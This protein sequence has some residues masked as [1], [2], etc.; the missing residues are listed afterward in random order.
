MLMQLCA[1]GLP[2]T[3]FKM[4]WVF[5]HEIFLTHFLHKI[6]CKKCV[7]K[8]LVKKFLVKKFLVKKF[9]VKKFLVKKFIVKKYRVKNFVLKNVVL[10]LSTYNVVLITFNEN[11]WFFENQNLKSIT[12]LGF[13]SDLEINWN[14]FHCSLIGGN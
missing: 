4:F 11:C 2:F 6:F 9:L 8:F 13:G 7:K 12:F 10:K 14:T 1:I 5:W 3:P